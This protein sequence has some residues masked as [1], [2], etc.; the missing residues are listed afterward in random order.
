MATPTLRQ[1][2]FLVALGAN[3]SFSRAA[4]ICH[5]TQPT[6]SAAIKE[7]ED[8][9]GVRLV[10]REARGAHL[11]HAGETAVRQ[12][13]I[14]LAEADE[15]VACVS[16]AGRPLEGPFQLGAIPT[17]APFV[18]AQTVTALRDGYPNVTLYL[19]EDKTDRLLECLR[20]HQLDAAII[21]LPWRAGG[22]AAVSAF[23]DEFLV[24]APARHRL[25]EKGDLTPEDLTD[26][27]MLLLDDGH[28]LREHAL[29]VCARSGGFRSA[30]VAA[31]SLTTLVNMVAG[32]LGVSLLPRLAIENGL[33]TGDTVAVRPFA[34]P[35]VGRSIGVAWRAGSSREAEARAVAEVLK[36][37]FGAGAQA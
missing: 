25:A 18:F 12:A 6:L 33:Q 13:S 23:D 5:V 36:E 31:T 22:I 4:E 10:E 26:E 30:E 2:R 20:T 1:L 14:V 17:I 29:S 34:E 8:L 7:L 21:A 32:G 15:F 19:H 9:L 37:T 16:S 11:T 24:A 3:G 35:V 28:C 27:D